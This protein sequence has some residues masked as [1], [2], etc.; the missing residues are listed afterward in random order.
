MFVSGITI[1]SKKA[2]VSRKSQL[3]KA[4]ECRPSSTELPELPE[5]RARTI[6]KFSS[7]AQHDK[8]RNS[9]HNKVFTSSKAHH[10]QE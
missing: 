3:P 6:N 10:K 4:E 1:E 5:L 8:T 9:S 2:S 7:A